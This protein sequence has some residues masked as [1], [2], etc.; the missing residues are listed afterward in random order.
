MSLKPILFNTEMVRA[1]LEGRKTV[2]RRVV[3]P[4]PAGKLFPMEKESCWPG[5][6][7]EARSARIVKP[8]YQPG[9]VLWV[10]ETF[11]Q[12]AKHTFW[13]KADSK[14]QNILWR[15]SIHMP[16][17]AA[18]IFLRV[19]DIKVERLQDI[20]CAGAL[21]EGCDGRCDC[22]SNGAEGV[23]SCITKDFSIE[24]F[25]TVWDRTIPKHPNKTKRYTYYWNDNPWVWVIE[26]EQIGREE[27][28]P[29][30]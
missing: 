29:V 28:E 17:E 25:Q 22:P 21:A 12:P 18:R 7:S 19:T 13:Y 6:W 10:R 23:L 11:A 1:L 4:Q 27:V 9:D 16:R 30:K 20:D 26:F 3:K 5:Y 24:R 15:P 8:P 2:T 14:V